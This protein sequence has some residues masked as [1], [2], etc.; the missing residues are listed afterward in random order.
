MQCKLKTKCPLRGEDSESSR[1]I[2]PCWRS[3]CDSCMHS[4]CSKLLLDRYEIPPEDRPDSDQVV[5]CTKTCF[6]KWLAA[7]KKAEKTAS[8]A[9]A[10]SEVK[11]RKVPWE[12]DGTL[13][14]LMDWLT[15][16][17]NYSSYAGSNGNVM[18]KSKA[19]FHKDIS[20]LIKAKIPD[21]DREPKDV[22]NKIVSLERQ[23]R[24]AMDWVN[25]TG[26]GVDNPGDFEAA[27]LKRCPLWKDLEPIM[28]E[29]PNSKPL[30]TNEDDDDYSIEED[31]PEEEPLEAP[32]TVAKA[33]DNQPGRSNN[34]PSTLSTDSL[35]SCP[36]KRLSAKSVKSVQPRK[37]GRKGDET[38][39]IISALMGDDESAREDYHALRLREVSARE[40]EAN[41]KEK[42]ANARQHEADARMIEAEANSEK[43]KAEAKAIGEKTKKETELMAIEERVK[44][45]RARK[46]CI[47]EGLCT[48]DDVDEYFPLPSKK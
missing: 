6:T 16:E 14:V 22:E 31:R 45:L 25:N 37:K 18:G 33:A 29:R 7:K 28:G 4:H 47:D 34:T 43:A 36:P 12:D 20:L 38:D 41:A 27:V 24:L 3:D 32:A 26:Q 9:A 23:F 35:I 30:C 8:K 11:K 21:S 17:G 15:T 40:K 2:H 5:F 1:D 19:Q 46:Q 42:E 44:L 48:A 39:V 10:E 13:S